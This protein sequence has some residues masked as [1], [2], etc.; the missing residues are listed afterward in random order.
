MGYEFRA[1]R[2]YRNGRE[3]LV[4]E[5]EAVKPVVHVVSSNGKTARFM[6]LLERRDLKTI[7]KERLDFSFAADCLKRHLYRSEIRNYCIDCFFRKACAF[8]KHYRWFL[9]TDMRKE[10]EEILEMWRKKNEM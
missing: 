7:R 1:K 9:K 2:F 4:T 5:P 3:E 8:P 6:R 10:A